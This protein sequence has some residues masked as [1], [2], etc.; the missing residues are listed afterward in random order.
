MRAKGRA[1]LWA[2]Q[3]DALTPVPVSARNYEPPAL[4][5][6][7]SANL[8]IYLM[9]LPEPSEAVRAA[10]HSG[11]ATLRELAIHGQ[12]WGKVDD[13]SGRRLTP[14]PGA[15]P[16]WARYYDVQ[17]L[18]PVFGERDKTLH[19]NID[20]ISLERRNGYSWF[21]A[22]PQQALLAYGKWLQRWSAGNRP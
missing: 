6:T 18:K 12:V 22:R 10:I 2:Q 1:L 11:V 16:L 8:L 13:A 15:G 4:S 20:D 21:N 19:D 17:T 5:S 9:S 14:K 3:Y 7:E